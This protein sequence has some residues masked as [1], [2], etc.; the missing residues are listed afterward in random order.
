MYVCVRMFHI[1][2]LKYRENNCVLKVVAQTSLYKK[3]I[4][5]DWM[6]P[7][8]PFFSLMITEHVYSVL[9]N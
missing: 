1:Y 6:V 9:N 7:W 8:K 4:E 3:S 5:V 2:F